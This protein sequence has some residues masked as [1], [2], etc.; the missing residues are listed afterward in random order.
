MAI[1]LYFQSLYTFYHN[2]EYTA[3]YLFPFDSKLLIYKKHKIDILYI[4]IS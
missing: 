2:D 4:D 3:G 1:L